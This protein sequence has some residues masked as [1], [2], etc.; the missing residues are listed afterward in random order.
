MKMRTLLLLAAVSAVV[1]PLSSDAAFAQTHGDEDL[2]LDS[3]MNLEISSAAKY[4][5]RARDA[6]ATIT[7]IS[8]EDIRRYGYRTLEEALASVRGFYTSNDRTYA[9]LGVRGF[10]RP[11]DYNDRIL[12]LLNGHSLNENVYGSALIGTELGWSLDNVAR[13]EIVRG[14]GSALYGTNAMFAVINVVTEDGITVDGVSVA[15]EAGDQGRVATSIEFGTATGS[16]LDL[17]GL[18]S[19]YDKR[20]ATLYY[21]EFDDLTS[22]YGVSAARDWDRSAG[23]V[24]SLSRGPWRVHGMAAHREKSVP[25]GAYDT[26]FNNPHSQTTE[27]RGFIEASY[28]IQHSHA[29]MTSMRAFFDNYLYEGT[30]PYD[31]VEYDRSDGNWVGLEG[32][33]RWD[34]SAAHR[35]IAGAEFQ[36]HVD[37]NYKY[38]SDESVYFLE[39][40]PS[41]LG[42]IYVQDEWQAASFLALTTGVRVDFNST[43][44]STLTPRTGLLVFPKDQSVL[45]LLYGEAFRSANVFERELG[46]GMGVLRGSDLAPER[47]RAYELA[48]ERRLSE[49]IWYAASAFRYSVHNLIEEV[50]IED[51]EGSV[52]RNSGNAHADGLEFEVNWRDLGAFDGDISYTLQEADEE[53]SEEILTNSPRHVFKLGVSA[54][55]TRIARVSVRQ[56][57]ESRRKTVYDTYTDAFMLTNLTLRIEPGNHC[58]NHSANLLHRVAASV[59]V[60]N[61]FDSDYKL[62]GGTEHRQ[63]GIP[64]EG[65]SVVARLTLEL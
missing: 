6:A 13:I 26:D 16:G 34:P 59:S 40:F 63:A 5:Q 54:P 4:S 12:L 11:T 61:V 46:D 45:K 17:S 49:A 30:W 9:Y 53:P 35:L 41:R 27:Q 18:V 44:R 57:I 3:L 48:W 65:R 33:M 24:F 8:A 7:V 19:W 22:N 31:V 47:I 58:A 42:A 14:P 38:W 20:G 51:G 25:T 15:A 28:R 36:E 60:Y 50:P 39:N 32:T 52:F 37:A 43:S 55:V 64:Q 10:S 1:L 29:L 23:G 2:S 62:P 21:R 56:Q